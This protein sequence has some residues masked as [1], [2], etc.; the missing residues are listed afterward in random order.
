MPAE[1]G[2]TAA[3]GRNDVPHRVG[4]RPVEEVEVV[5][6]GDVGRVEDALRRLIAKTGRCH[7]R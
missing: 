7:G 3:T 1:K 4:G 6:V 5:V 2:D